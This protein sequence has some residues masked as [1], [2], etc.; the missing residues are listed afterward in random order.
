MV[1]KQTSR[2]GWRNGSG[3]LSKPGLWDS[4]GRIYFCSSPSG[5]VRDIQRPVPCLPDGSEHSQCLASVL[6]CFLSGERPD[7]R[8]VERGNRPLPRVHCQP[9]Q[10]DERGCHDAGLRLLPG[11]SGRNGHRYGPVGCF[12]GLWVGKARLNPFIATLGMNY[13]AAGAALL[14]TG[15]DSISGI[16]SDCL[17]IMGWIA[18]GTF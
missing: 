18:K 12:T 7:L 16:P 17:S 2:W 15:G 6:G 13:I 10:R 5:H 14:Y 1:P 8:P 3:F 9:R 11:R 4:V